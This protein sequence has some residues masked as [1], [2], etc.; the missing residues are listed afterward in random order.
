[1]LLLYLW[2]LF[3]FV[4]TPAFAMMELCSVTWESVKVRKLNNESDVK[5]FWLNNPIILSR[6]LFSY[7]LSVILSEWS[8][9]TPCS[10]CIPSASL[11]H[12]T[13]Q[14]G[15]ISGSKMVSIQSR[16]RAC[17]DLDSGLPV[18]RQEEESQCPGPLIEERL[19]PDANICRG[20]GVWPRG[21]K[22]VF[23]QLFF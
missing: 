6:V 18:T 11:Q 22:E 2:L 19:C 4:T 7:L 23:F 20:N 21:Q 12:N 16:F 5:S 1:M 10:P 9:W 14:A 8:E 3:L 15:V 13:S 17:L